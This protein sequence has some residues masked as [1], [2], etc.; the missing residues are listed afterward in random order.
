[1]AKKTSIVAPT[2]IIILQVKDIIWETKEVNH[3]HWATH[4]LGW[5]CQGACSWDFEEPFYLQQPIASKVCEALKAIPEPPQTLLSLPAKVSLSQLLQRVRTACTLSSLTGAMLSK[6]RWGRK[7][8]PSK[9]NS[10]C[11][12]P[13]TGFLR[14]IQTA[15]IQTYAYTECTHMPRP[16]EMHGL[17]DVKN[18]CQILHSHWLGLPEHM[19]ET[20]RQM[21]FHLFT[22]L[23]ASSRQAWDKELFS[24]SVIL[25]FA[26][27][28]KAV[29]FP[30]KKQNTYRMASPEWL[31]QGRA[32]G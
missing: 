5:V 14:R 15:I 16:T 8:G 19:N 12:K 18:I 20:W 4:S 31:D 30:F 2:S 21:D 7:S 17:G 9:P 23:L 10:Y 1:M 11:W 29:S 6:G 26:Q 22:R 28:A 24:L 25:L 3:R 27:M 13:C 32:G